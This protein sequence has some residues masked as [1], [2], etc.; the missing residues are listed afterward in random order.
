ME[1]TNTRQAQ[2]VPDGAL[3][4]ESSE[5]ATPIGSEDC[6]LETEAGE[7]SWKEPASYLPKSRKLF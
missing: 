5:R 6:G 1:Q 7:V 4:A 2:Q 3:Q